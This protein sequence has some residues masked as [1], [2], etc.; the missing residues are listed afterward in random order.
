[1][2]SLSPILTALE[3]SHA[4]LN[5][6]CFAGSL[7]EVPT[8]T[9]Q[10]KGKRNALGWYAAERWQNET[11]RPSELNISAEEL[12]RPASEVLETLLHEMVH[13]KAHQ[14]GIKDCSRGGAYHNGRFKVLAEAAGLECLPKTKKHGYGITKL[15][16]KGLRVIESI[17]S[18]VEPVLVLARRIET[19]TGKA[20]KMLLYQCPCGVKIRSGRKD[21]AARCNDCLD[22]F[23]LQGGNND[24]E[25]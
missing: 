14:S 7:K 2:N 10:T 20:G 5:R 16:P 15:G 1:M 9:L 6:E 24:D 8:I 22:D 13:Q 17:R 23:Q 12:K 11:S 3:E 4:V 18:K 25:N 21:L 19:S